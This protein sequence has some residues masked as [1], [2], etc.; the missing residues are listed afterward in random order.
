MFLKKNFYCL[1]KVLKKDRLACALNIVPH[2]PLLQNGS[3]K[4]SDEINS[5]IVLCHFQYFVCFSISPQD[6]Y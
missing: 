1:F 2:V 6:I 4:F 3:G 5:N